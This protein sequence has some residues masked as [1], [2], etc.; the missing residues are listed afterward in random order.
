MDWRLPVQKAE[1]T[2]VMYKIELRG[3]ERVSSGEKQNHRTAV[4]ETL[5]RSE[6]PNKDRP[7]QR[8][9]P[10]RKPKCDADV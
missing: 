10:S 8:K 1:P 4:G 3:G 5:G 9:K 6:R 2:V 7:K